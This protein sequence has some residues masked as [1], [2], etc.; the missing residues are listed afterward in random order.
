MPK[1][2]KSTRNSDAMDAEGHEE[3]RDVFV[4]FYRVVAV[5]LSSFLSL[6]V[7]F[8]ALSLEEVNSSNSFNSIFN[9]TVARILTESL[10][11]SLFLSLFV[12]LAT[13]TTMS[14][15]KR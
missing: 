14:S 13:T 15:W 5:F 7:S 1:A 12:T 10:C 11:L 2:R 8:Y 3:V 6:S 4:V 9:S